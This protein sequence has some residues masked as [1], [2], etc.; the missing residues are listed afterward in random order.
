VHINKTTAPLI[1]AMDPTTL[2]A[3]PGKQQWC[4][5]RKCTGHWTVESDLKAR[6]DRVHHPDMKPAVRNALL[7]RVWETELVLPDGK[8][9]C[10]DGA[11]AI[12]GVTRR[13][14]YY[15]SK[16]VGIG[17][18]RRGALRRVIQAWWMDYILMLDKMPDDDS[19]QISKPSKRSVYQCYIED[20][21][22][23]PDCY[24]D[25]SP[26][27]FNALWTKLYPKVRLRRHMRF[28]KC[29]ECV[30]LRRIKNDRSRRRADRDAAHKKLLDHYEYIK[31]ARALIQKKKNDGITNPQEYMYMS[32][33]G[34]N[35]LPFGFPHFA[36]TTKDEKKERIETKLMIAYVHGI[37]TY[38]Y[39]IFADIKGDPNLNIECLQRT[40]K[41]VE[42]KQGT[43]AKTLYLQLDNCFRENKN[44]Y[45]LCYLAW[46]IERG[47]FER[48]ELSFLP[49][50]HTHNECDQVLIRGVYVIWACLLSFFC[51]FQHFRI[52]DTVNSII[53]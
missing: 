8:K 48:I 44:A 22:Q 19:Y 17:L 15:R 37:G 6:R 50:G 12:L 49:V 29:T 23:W 16:H 47:V 27:Y 30:E 3:T 2:F 9:A 25:C 45:V 51:L 18:S 39:D 43:L 7:N 5:Q 24:D 40:L 31:G 14:L 11:A 53:L 41:H 21:R 34:T 13:R 4:C 42:K 10:G 32:L 35:A 26:T 1:L 20:C 52:F 46:L 28:S 36:E 38:T 33:D